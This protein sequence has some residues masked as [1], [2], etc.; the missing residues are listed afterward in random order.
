MKPS[1]VRRPETRL[2]TNTQEGQ[3]GRPVLSRQRDAVA[4]GVR[5]AGGADGLDERARIGL[6]EA[7]VIVRS[8]RAH[9]TVE[10]RMQ[11]ACTSAIVLNCRPRRPQPA[12]PGRVARKSTPQAL[13]GLYTGHTSAWS[14]VVL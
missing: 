2:G 13:R 12:R 10:D 1:N 6:H 3:A 7:H 14:R 5:S 8:Q 9:P 4:Q 11:R